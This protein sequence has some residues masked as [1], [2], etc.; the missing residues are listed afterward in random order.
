MVIG[1][2]SRTLTA[3]EKN[4]H[5]HSGKL[6]FLAMKWA[7]CERF[8]E[9]LY[10]APSFTVYTDNNPLTYVLSTAKLNATTHRWIAELADFRFSIKYRPGRVNRD[11]DGLLQ[12]PLD[13]EHY[14]HTC[15]Q[16]MEPEVIRTGTQALQL[17]SH[18]RE[19]WLCPATI[20]AA[21]TDVEQE[22][23]AHP[24]AEIPLE[25]LRKAQEDDPVIGKV[26]QYVMTGQWPRLEGRDRRDDISV[27]ARERNKLYVNQ[28][29]ILYRKSVAR[30]QLVL[31]TAFHQ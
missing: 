26:R 4:Y 5:L 20:T 23:V 18:K 9:Y 14:I 13:M 19:P 12:M 8:R 6:E 22:R 31:P 29:G 21:C 27:L 15:S 10:Y 16:E 24:V 2:G 11:A 30:T 25:N 28:D 7:I 17:E 3:P 1:Y